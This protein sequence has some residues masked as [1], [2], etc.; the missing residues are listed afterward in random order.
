MKNDRYHEAEIVGELFSLADMTQIISPLL[1]WMRNCDVSIQE[2]KKPDYPGGPTFFGWV[3]G[4]NRAA[5]EC[6][7]HSG[8]TIG[9]VVRSICAVNQFHPPPSEA[10]FLLE[11]YGWC[12]ALPLKDENQYF[13][14]S[15]QPELLWT[16]TSFA[17]DTARPNRV[18]VDLEW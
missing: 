14:G 11:K 7:I 10:A 13:Y 16:P 8:Y 5:R 18:P 17:P 3:G 1:Y 6:R 4:Y 9:E 12:P 2:R 15:A